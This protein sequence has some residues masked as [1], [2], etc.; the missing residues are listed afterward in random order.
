LRASSW[1]LDIVVDAKLDKLDLKLRRVRRT[2]RMV[3]PTAYEAGGAAGVSLAIN[4]AIR[5]TS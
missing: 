1:L 2:T 4:P 5:G 3:S